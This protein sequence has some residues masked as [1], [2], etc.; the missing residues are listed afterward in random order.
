MAGRLDVR[1]LQVLSKLVILRFSVPL[2]VAV[3]PRRDLDGI[4]Q[5]LHCCAEEKRLNPFLLGDETEPEETFDCSFRV[6]GNPSRLTSD[7]TNSAA[8]PVIRTIS[9]AF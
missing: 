1:I 5:H 4:P 8:N 6:S 3:V 9:D 7:P 2:G